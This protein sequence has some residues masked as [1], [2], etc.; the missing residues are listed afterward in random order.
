MR[1]LVCLDSS[2]YAD[3]ILSEIGRRAW[4]DGT[5]FR[6][7][8]VLELSNNWDH[9]QEIMRQSQEILSERVILLQSRLKGPIKVKGEVLEGSA[10]SKINEEAA[11]WTAD[12]ILM[13]SHGDTG[14]RKEGLGS[15]A[16]AVVNG[17]PCSVEVIKLRAKHA[18]ENT[19]TVS[20][21]AKV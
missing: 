17:A 9:D 8:T 16:A 6:L 1:V 18:H 15:V 20:S 21:G 14:I 7:I 10:V 13:G 3:E 5:F 11:E 2:I 12:L 19:H 4:L